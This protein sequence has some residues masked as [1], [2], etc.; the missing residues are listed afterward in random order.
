M[1]FMKLFYTLL[2][3]ASSLLA[4]P[5]IQVISV[6]FDSPYMEMEFRAIENQQSLDLTIENLLIKEVNFV[7]DLVELQRDG[8]EYRLRWIPTFT[9]TDAN[10]IYYFEL[11]IFDQ[12][13]FV[14][15]NINFGALNSAL[16][17][18]TDVQD[19]TRFQRIVFAETN[20]IRQTN[21]NVF[22]GRVIDNNEQNVYLNDVE[23]RTDNFN[24][25]WQGKIGPDDGE[26]PPMFARVGDRFTVDFFIDTANYDP[27]Y[28]DI[29]TVTYEDGAK[30]YLPLYA[31]PTTIEKNINLDLLE[32]DGGEVFVP[33][34]DIIVRW[35]G[36]TP[37]VPVDVFL[38]RN[39][40]DSLLGSS[41]SNTFR[42][43][44]PEILSENYK[45]RIAQEF[46]IEETNKVPLIGSNSDFFPISI[47]FNSIGNY[48]IAIDPN[49]KL[50]RVNTAA[51]QIDGEFQ[52]DIPPN[53]SIK[54]I[55]YYQDKVLIVFESRSGNIIR[56][57]DLSPLDLIY[58]ENI[59]GGRLKKI[60]IDSENA[61]LYLISEYG[62]FVKVFDIETGELQN[63]IEN[64]N[65]IS[66]FDINIENDIIATVD[67]RSK[68]EVRS[69]ST[70]EILN[71][72]D[73]RGLPYFERLEISPNGRIIGLV[74]KQFSITGRAT[75]I[76]IFDRQTNSV[77]RILDA[78]ATDPIN[79]TFSPSSNY[80]VIASPTNPKIIIHDL[81]EGTESVWGGVTG[82]LTDVQ[83]AENQSLLGIAASSGERDPLQYVK[84]SYPETD[85]S[86]D[87]FAIRE[88]TA[89]TSNIQLDPEYIYNSSTVNITGSICNNSD[90]P[91]YLEGSY[92]FNGA[93]FDLDHQFPD[94]LL[95]GECLKFDLLYSPR[96]VGE[97]SDTL[98]FST[99]SK[100]FLIPI[101][102]EGLPRNLA[103]DE[104]PLN[105]GEVCVGDTINT[106]IELFRNL[107]SVP[108]LINSVKVLDDYDNII[109]II[110]FEEDIILGPNEIFSIDISATPEILGEN[111]AVVEV[112][113]FNQVQY[114]SE[115][116]LEILGIGTVF[117]LSHNALPFISEQ[118]TR[119]LVVKNPGTN[120][121]T[122]LD[123]R[124]DPEEKFTTS[125]E[126]PQ[127][128][129]PGD[130]LIFEITWDLTELENANLI[131][132]ADPCPVQKFVPLDEWS[133]NLLVF[134]EDVIAD[135]PI[136]ETDIGIF[137]S[138]VANYPYN[139]NLN[140]EADIL[141]NPRLFFPEQF[142]SK[143]ESGFENL[144]VD[145]DLRTINIRATGN[146]FGRD[147]IGIL[148]GVAGIAETDF[149]NITIDDVRF[150]EEISI[151]RQTGSLTVDSLCGS[152]RLIHSG[153]TLEII[154]SYPNPAS[155]KINIDIN[156]SKDLKISLHIFHLNGNLIN[157]EKFNLEEGINSLEIDL[158]ALSSGSYYISIEGE[159][160][161]FTVNI[162]KG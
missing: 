73:F 115:I 139:G 74:T 162:S 130:S 51:N 49:G 30:S 111:P 124:P 84:Y 10:R 97:I 69:L 114:I 80:M 37:S 128:I 146:Y 157:S 77:A 47:D 41:T 118:P 8:G 23:F 57:Y 3:F 94:T 64:N 93:N 33:C 67:Y 116:D 39:G 19:A 110:D 40:V 103:S 159:N 99:C 100:D 12:D 14:S 9:Q 142:I 92:F 68:L 76:L 135:N 90:L 18:F 52:V 107:D 71:E 109:E 134:V 113:Y 85:I 56:L 83:Y 91:I 153:A 61:K 108:I 78:A 5:T 48:L 31:R 63:E 60:Q 127:I 88:P 121:I 112:N 22:R 54:E 140:F 155:D 101:F 102:G 13:F 89:E 123:I 53:H 150:P 11:I 143:Y 62:Y 138:L 122:I 105:L 144:G 137:Y 24:Y 149:T 44:A 2:L 42:F 66:S 28:F 82:V 72:F 87:V 132:D 136:G 96:V 120:P 106:E 95:P 43:K 145:N 156:A 26:Q 38:S 34:E 70:G 46:R 131:F 98:A 15:T 104:N 35:E 86:N 27:P 16:V 160:Q 152:R 36:N 129:E 133:G 125:P 75:E 4:Q 45:V 21:V 17:T 119:E 25:F 148:K 58:E 20:N 50:L 81:S 141:L 7:P 32:P 1:P 151:Q 158:S 161:K 154:S 147:T 29:F 6:E 65:I 55:K 59:L 117:D 79:L 126:F